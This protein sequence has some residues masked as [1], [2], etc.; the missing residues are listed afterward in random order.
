MLYYIGY[1][2]ILYVAQYV[3]LYVVLYIIVIVF[4]IYFDIELF[5]IEQLGNKIIPTVLLIG[6]LILNFNLKFLFDIRR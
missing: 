2:D 1:S 4:I 5:N 6:I 3:V